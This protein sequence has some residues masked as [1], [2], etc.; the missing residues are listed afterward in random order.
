[1]LRFR[2]A[3]CTQQTGGLTPGMTLRAIPAALPIIDLA[4]TSTPEQISLRS[5]CLSVAC[6]RHDIAFNTATVQIYALGPSGPFWSLLRSWLRP[7][8]GISQDKLPL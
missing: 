5:P 6:R 8:R 2:Q 4:T 1:M 3:Y 7:Y